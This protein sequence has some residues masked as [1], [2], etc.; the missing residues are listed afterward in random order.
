[1]GYKGELQKCAHFISLTLLLSVRVRVRVCVFACARAWGS[2]FLLGLF[3]VF[4]FVLV[5]KTPSTHSK[6]ENNLNLRWGCISHF[7]PAKSIMFERQI[8]FSYPSLSL[9]QCKDWVTRSFCHCNAHNKSQYWKG[10]RDFALTGVLTM[11]NL[12]L[13]EIDADMQHGGE[14]C[15]GPSELYHV[16]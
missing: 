12:E 10:Q 5:W 3:C 13:S 16:K 1:M 15:V 7:L 9:S 6:L 14:Y 8:E 11:F 2:Q 4:I